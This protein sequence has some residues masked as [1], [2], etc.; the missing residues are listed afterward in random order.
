MQGVYVETQHKLFIMTSVY[1]LDSTFEETGEYSIPYME[2]EEIK[3]R[4]TKAIVTGK[5]IGRAHV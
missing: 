5:Q 1:F 3:R 4:I 2:R